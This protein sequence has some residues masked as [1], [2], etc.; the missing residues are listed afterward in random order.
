M[1]AAAGSLPNGA[2]V[3]VD[4]DP[5]LVLGDEVL[6]WTPAGYTERRPRPAEAEL[7]TPPSVVAVLRAGWTS[8]VPFL[9]QSAG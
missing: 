5:W 1:H 9:H 6:R 2:F 4:G 3:L 7:V 8:S